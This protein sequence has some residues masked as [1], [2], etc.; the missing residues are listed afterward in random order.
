[1]VDKFPIQNIKTEW[2]LRD[3]VRLIL[4]NQEEK[5]FYTISSLSKKLNIPR[6]TLIHY[7]AILEKKGII[8]KERIE[9]G[10][11]GRPTI[12]KITKEKIDESNKQIEKRKRDDLELLKSLDKKD[13]L[14]KDTLSKFKEN[15]MIGKTLTK[16]MTFENMGF[17]ENYD[18]L[19]EKG[20]EF[21]KEH[22]NKIKRHQISREDKPPIHKQN[23]KSKDYKKSIKKIESMLNTIKDG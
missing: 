10:S 3:I 9:E 8:E 2:I 18:R 4:K 13:I 19:T 7:L 11:T 20:K 16:L 12:I 1:M 5:K 21:L 23:I 14:R 15:G 17:I 22:K 6:S